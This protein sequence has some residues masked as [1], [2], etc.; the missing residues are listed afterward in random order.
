MNVAHH[1]SPACPP[2]PWRQLSSTLDALHIRFIIVTLLAAI[3]AG[4]ASVSSTR[5]SSQDFLL[6]FPCQFK[7][8]ERVVGF[9]LDLKREGKILAVNRVPDD[10]SISMLVEAGDSTMSGTPNHGASAFQDTAPLQRFVTVQWDRL[11]FDVTGYI[12]VTRD[13]NQEQTNYFTK[14]DFILE[15]V[16]PDSVLKP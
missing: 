8:G 3:A 11:P 7:P 4:C 15:R 5:M 16:A 12:V 13:F 14:A 10:W 1:N 9:E 2:K 6:S